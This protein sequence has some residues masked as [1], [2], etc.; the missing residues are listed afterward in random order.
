MAAKKT[1]TRPAG[2]T[3]HRDIAAHINLTNKAHEWAEKCLAYRKAGKA[4][5]AGAAEAKERF[6]LKKV[7]ALELQAVSGKPIGGRTARD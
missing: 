2:L 5:R 3:I 6:W 1:N 4:A 7:M